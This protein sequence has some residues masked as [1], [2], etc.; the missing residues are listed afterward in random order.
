LAAA[1]LKWGKYYPTIFKS[2]HKYWNLLANIHKD[3][4]HLKRIMYTTDPLESFHRTIRKV[5]KK[6][7][8]YLIRKRYSQVGLLGYTK[9]SY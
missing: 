7:K 1:E 6:K 8:I 4:P 2:W 9:R 3:F 5:I